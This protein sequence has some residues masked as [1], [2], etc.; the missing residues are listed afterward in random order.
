MTSCERNLLRWE[1]MPKE[2][3]SHFLDFADI[4]KLEKVAQQELMEINIC[5]KIFN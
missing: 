1:E 2:K 5:Q 3:K 4:P